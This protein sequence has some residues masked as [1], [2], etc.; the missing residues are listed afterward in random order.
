MRPARPADVKEPTDPQKAV[1]DRISQEPSKKPSYTLAELYKDAKDDLHPIKEMVDEMRAG[2]VLP[3]A[4]KVTYNIHIKRVLKGK[5]NLAIADGSVTV[6]GR[7][8]YT[9]EGLR[10]GVFTSTDNF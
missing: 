9:A 7:E 2:Q 1:L 5:L 10:V 6:D 3:T 8:I 4:K